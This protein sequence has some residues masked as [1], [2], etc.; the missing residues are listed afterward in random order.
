MMALRNLLAMLSLSAVSAARMV[1]HESRLAAPNGFISQGA[2]P[3]DDMLTLRF[4]LASN[5]IDGL[6][7]KLMSLSTPGS[8]EFRQWL[9]KDEVR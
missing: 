8:P 9:S 6:K 5:N 1:I 2:A 4:A 3:A 7:A